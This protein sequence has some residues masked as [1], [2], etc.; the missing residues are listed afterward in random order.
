M[1]KKKQTIDVNLYLIP[2]NRV[3]VSIRK[4]LK[5]QKGIKFVQWK[6]LN[7]SGELDIVLYMQRD[8]FFSEI[9][10][11]DIRIRPEHV[12]NAVQQIINE[13][14]PQMYQSRYGS[15][16]PDLGWLPFMELSWMDVSKTFYIKP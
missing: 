4:K 11:A 2:Y 9:D 13:Q 14:L 6:G 15:H 3:A 12:F 10:N 5:Q 7:R 1:A 8:L 16:R